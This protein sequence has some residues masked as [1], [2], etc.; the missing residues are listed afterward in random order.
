MIL[1]EEIYNE[2][3]HNILIDSKLLKNHNRD[4]NV[5]DIKSSKIE[6]EKK[7]IL[8]VFDLLTELQETQDD[9]T[10]RTL[11]SSIISSLNSC[12]LDM[13]TIMQVFNTDEEIALLINTSDLPDVTFCKTNDIIKITFP[14]LLPR[15]VKYGE[16]Q[17]S[18]ELK[19]ISLMYGKT[20]YDY[21]QK[22]PYR[23]DRK[24]VLCFI[25]HFNSR[26]TMKDHDNFDLKL[27]ID[28]LANNLLPDDSP[29][30]CSHYMDYVMDTKDFSEIFIVPEDQ[31]IDFI[32][33]FKRK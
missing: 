28:Y 27:I 20:F 9:E 33:E 2:T 13:T 5:N 6:S 12:F 4:K 29:D 25:N 21:F 16:K 30:Y 26:Q 32:K 3:D 19:R 24:V 22:A 1:K 18:I 23:Y 17:Y 14:T 7:K 11:C 10:I 15:R 8:S 31:F